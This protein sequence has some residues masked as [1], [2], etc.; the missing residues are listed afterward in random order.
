MLHDDVY[1][2]FKQKFPQF[3]KQIIQWF[4]NGRNSIRVRRMDGQDFI[5]TYQGKQNYSLETVDSFID[6]LK[7]KEGV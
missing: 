5:F 6:R 4:P 3:S 1:K 7:R 2:Q